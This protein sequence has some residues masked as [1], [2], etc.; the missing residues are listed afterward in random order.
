M[1][2]FTTSVFLQSRIIC[3]DNFESFIFLVNNQERFYLQRNKVENKTTKI[4]SKR[5]EEWK[6]H[7]GKSKTH[8]FN[9]IKIKEIK[10]WSEAN[11]KLGNLKRPLQKYLIEKHIVMMTISGFWFQRFMIILERV[12]ATVTQI[13]Y[14]GNDSWKNVAR[15]KL[16]LFKKMS[17]RKKENSLTQL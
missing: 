4:F 16:L 17:I 1:N 12:I 9:K 13:S 8:P 2:C 3:K 14:R 10:K 7:N 15:K 5:S 11:I 6:V